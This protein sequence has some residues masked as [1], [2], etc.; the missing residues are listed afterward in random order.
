MRSTDTVARIGGDEFTILLPDSKSKKK[1]KKTAERILD[2]FSTPFDVM[3]ESIE[4]GISIGIAL[5]PGDGEDDLTLSCKADE[6]MYFAKQ[7]GRNCM[8]FWSKMDV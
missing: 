3:G 8:K 2:E 6:A 5:Y 4:I 1:A 7:S